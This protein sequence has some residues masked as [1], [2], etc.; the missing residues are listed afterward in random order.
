MPRFLDVHH[1]A[2]GLTRDQVAEAHAK[3][4]AVQAKHGVSF[5]RYWYDEVTGKIFCL[6]DAPTREAVLAT[7]REAHGGLADD[8]FEVIEGE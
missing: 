6:S 1:H 2:Q 4:L 7:H 5:V 8:I 3:D